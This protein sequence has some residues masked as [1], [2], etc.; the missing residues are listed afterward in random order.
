VA[1]TLVENLKMLNRKERFFLI[2]EA[3]G[4]R[5]FKLDSGFRGRL[6]RT[7]GLTVPD[8]TFV[9]MDYHLN[10]LYAA[11]MLTY[12]PQEGG[13]YPDPDVYVEENQEDVDLLVAWDLPEPHVIMIE[14]KGATYFTHKQMESK[15]RRLVKIFGQEAR[16]WDSVTPHLCLVSPRESKG[17]RVDKAPG[18]ARNGDKYYWMRLESWCG[19]R[20]AA[21]TRCDDDGNVSR[22]GG[23]W[24]LTWPGPHC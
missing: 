6:G 15:L 24:K 5:D 18:W 9:A 7:L 4:N 3:L 20:L 14:A 12:R 23:H 16:T 1:T 21:V 10:W 22:I 17:L 11:L 8:D 19:Q 2:G 13:C